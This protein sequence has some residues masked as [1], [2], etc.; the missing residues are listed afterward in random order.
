MASRNQSPTT[1]DQD[2]IELLADDHAA[3]KELFAEFKKFQE[4]KAQGVDE[5][6]QALMDAVCEALKVHMQIEEEIFYPAAR[7]ALAGEADLMNE[8][9]VEH[10]AA[11]ELIAQIE[12][13]SA[14]DDMTCAQFIVLSEQIDH[15]VKDEEGEMFPKLRKASLDMQALGRKL[16]RRRAELETANVPAGV[17]KASIWERLSAFGR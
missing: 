5:M 3:V 8:A 15:H 16:A 1:S 4:A 10:Q 14:R 2:A 6:K 17:V 13:G 9:V 7:Q 12:A 11:R